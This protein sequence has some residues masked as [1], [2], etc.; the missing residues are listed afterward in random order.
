MAGSK[1]KTPQ[2][3]TLIAAALRKATSRG[4]A[5]YSQ[6]VATVLKENPKIIEAESP[7][8]I[9]AQMLSIARQYGNL[10]A[11][12]SSNV[13]PDLFGEYPMGPC[14]YI[15]VTDKNGSTQQKLVPAEKIT[16]DQGRK[17][18]E[19]HKQRPKRSRRLFA[20]ERAIKELSPYGTG[21]STFAECWKAKAAKAKKTG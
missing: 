14:V 7:A 3:R 15:D 1:S 19:T 2:T 6:V 16:L 11:K 12:S 10:H 8:L 20:M 5:V 17:Y 9:E 21:D 13:E 4:G 18:L